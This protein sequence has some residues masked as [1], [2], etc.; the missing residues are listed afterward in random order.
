MEEDIKAL[1]RIYKSSA[2]NLRKVADLAREKD[3][4]SVVAHKSGA[5]ADTYEL[6][7][8]DLENLI[9]PRKDIT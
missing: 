7:I 6:V 5:K 1:I 8:D 2:I 4:D 9:H 3:I